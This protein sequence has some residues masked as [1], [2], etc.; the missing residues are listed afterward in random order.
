MNTATASPA[1]IGAKF[2][3]WGLRLFVF[4]LVFGFVPL[5]HY[6]H[7]SF[8]LVGEVFLKRVTLWW[9]CAFQL[10]VD[11]AQIGGLAMVALGLCYTVLAR[12]GAIRSVTSAER[13]APALCV[14][15]I[16]AEAVA[17]VV[18]YYVVAKVWPNFFYAPVAAGKNLWLAM[19]IVC[20]AIYVTGVVFAAGGIKRALQANNANAGAPTMSKGRW[21]LLALL[22]GIPLGAYWIYSGMPMI[23]H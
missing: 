14:G 3:R 11:V 5:L 17:S 23:C 8:E 12:G 7:G 13:M 1:E 4:G 22:A 9:G 18:G 21:K 15:G 6:M 20:I 19:Q 2:I 10:A 16:L